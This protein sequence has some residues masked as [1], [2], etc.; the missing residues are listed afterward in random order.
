M[1]VENKFLNNE[2]DANIFE[3][4]CFQQ[5][6]ADSLFGG[7]EEE[8]MMIILFFVVSAAFDRVQI[9]FC[10]QMLARQIHKQGPMFHLCSRKLFFWN[11]RTPFELNYCCLICS[12]V[13]APAKRDSPF[14]SLDNSVTARLR[15]VF[16]L[17]AQNYASREKL[18]AC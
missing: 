10:A 18:P 13:N 5:A 16:N 1:N 8:H 9:A 4:Q 12:A 17:S 7:R 6:R 14:S 15:G 11:S 2:L 3:T